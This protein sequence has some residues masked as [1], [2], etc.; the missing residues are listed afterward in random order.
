MNSEIHNNHPDTTLSAERIELGPDV[1]DVVKD[2]SGNLVIYR[3]VD[4]LAQGKTVAGKKL[5]Y[6]NEVGEAVFENAHLLPQPIVN[7]M[8]AGPH[9]YSI[10][11]ELHR[12]YSGID[13]NRMFSEFDTHLFFKNLGRTVWVRLED[14]TTWAITHQPDKK[15]TPTSYTAKLGPGYVSTENYV[16]SLGLKGRMTTFVSGDDAAELWLVEIENTT[17][18]ERVID[19]IPAV[20]VYGGDRR[21]VE[22][23]RDVVRLYNKTFVGENFV[24]ICPGLEWIE[25]RSGRSGIR[26]IMGASTEDNR[27]PDRIYSDRQ[28]FMGRDYSWANPLSIRADLPPQM[29]CLGKEPIGALEYKNIRLKPGEIF[30]FSVINGI[31]LSVEE[32]KA[33]V[34]KYDFAGVQKAKEQLDNFWKE[35]TSRVTIK[36]GDKDFDTGWNIWYL[37]QVILRYWFGNTGHPQ[38]DYGEDHIGWREIWQDMM[39]TLLVIPEKAL[40]YFEY[41]L[42]GIRPDGTNA[43]RFFARTRRF[44]TD[45]VNGLWCDHPYYTTQTVLLMAN[46]LCDP[47]LLLKDGIKYFI[48]CYRDRGTVKDTQWEPGTVDFVK[49]ESGDF[50]TG[51]VLEHLL[52]QNYGMYFD[53][54]K[55]GI[56]HQMRAGWNDALDQIKGGENA[57][58]SFGLTK[59]LKDLADYLEVL[60]GRGTEQVEL[61]EELAMLIDKTPG[62]RYIPDQ[63][64]EIK[65]EYFAKVYSS[66]SGKKVSVTLDELIADLRGKHDAMADILR[67]VSWN[68]RYC[69]GYFYKDGSSVDSYRSDDDFMIMLMAQAYGLISGVLDEE[70]VESAVESANK[71]LFDKKIGGYKLNYPPGT[72]FDPAIGRMTGF[73]PGTKENN[74]IFCHANLFYAYALLRNKKANAAFKVW[75]GVNPLNH[76]HSEART[77]PWLPEYYISSDNPNHAGR[78]E[79]PIQTG[80][81]T[82]TRYVFQQYFMGVRGTPDGLLIDPCFP[83]NEQFKECSIKALYRGE[84]FTVMFHNESWKT[85]NPAVKKVVVDGDL[86]DG[87]V[88]NPPASPEHLVE[89]W[90]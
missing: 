64:T 34:E 31:A 10:V 26:Y 86:V 19:V 3:K 58:Y 47:G 2:E 8:A 53:V 42:S 12:G 55:N 35:L 39:A 83:S 17:D 49:T 23:H 63:K 50:A 51:T 75:E 80:T 13:Y 4:D 40:D 27:T 25:R 21:Y 48:D 30:R 90:L 5:W 16:E 29:D 59:N 57:V 71:W 44:G 89:V 36:T 84:T 33:M 43:T 52:A 45:E 72:S 38:I 6:F 60:K 65:R 9:Y 87:N 85:E 15:I 24:E 11:D 54:G 74:A 73:A 1:L 7:M 37:V 14:K 67:E 79:Y 18:Q 69:T 70:Q 22:Y 28:T 76:E 66:L 82:W 41:S 77:G 32:R 61:F 56:L 88:V 68:G 20:P 46:T 78:G 62:T 81:A